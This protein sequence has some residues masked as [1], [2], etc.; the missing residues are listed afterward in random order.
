MKKQLA[1]VALLVLSTALL[2]GLG[3]AQDNVQEFSLIHS[4]TVG[5]GAPAMFPSQLT[6]K[7][8]VPVRLFNI[9]ADVTH[10]PVVISSDMG[11]NNP[12]FGVE[13]FRVVPGE[14][15]VVEFTPDKT[16]AFFITHLKHGHNIVGK[17]IVTE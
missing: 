10:D 9:S 13:G 7:V 4:L 3:Q 2:G 8:G 11:G 12:V 6:V 17:L 5:D 1:F 15:T 16:G 14:I